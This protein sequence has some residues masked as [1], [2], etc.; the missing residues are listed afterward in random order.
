MKLGGLT[1]I[2]LKTLGSDSAEIRGL[3]ADMVRSPTGMESGSSG[4]FGSTTSD[5]FERL[6]AHV[7]VP[8]NELHVAMKAAMKDPELFHWGI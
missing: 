4:K 7:T 6:R 2:G 3:A 1:E 5:I 8:H